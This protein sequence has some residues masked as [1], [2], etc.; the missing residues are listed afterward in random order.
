MTFLASRR[1]RTPVLCRSISCL[2][3]DAG[4]LKTNFQHHNGGDWLTKA[5][6]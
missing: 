2:T 1:L 5:D 4:S 3:A 6:P